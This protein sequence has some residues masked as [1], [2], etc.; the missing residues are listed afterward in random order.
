MW[1]VLVVEGVVGV[2]GEAG[3][4]DFGYLGVVGEVLDYF[5]GILYVTLDAE[6]KGLCALEEYPC[7][8]RGNGGS[9]SRCLA[10]MTI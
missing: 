3:V 1:E 8:E 5:E 7:V 6:G 9:G 10:G 2:C 4:I